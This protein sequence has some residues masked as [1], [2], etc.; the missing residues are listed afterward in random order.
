MV[1]LEDFEAP[2]MP[3]QETLRKKL[4]Q[5]LARFR[6]EKRPAALASAGGLESAPESLVERAAPWP[7]LEPF[8]AAV[9]AAV[10]EWLARPAESAQA[11]VF[12]L[13]PG[14]EFDLMR[15][16][17]EHRAAEAVPPPPSRSIVEGDYSALPRLDGASELVVI[18]R[19]EDWFRRHHAGLA[20]VRELIARLSRAKG[21][22]V[23]GV[24]SWAWR[25]LAPAADTN[26]EMPEP[27]T[28][29]P[30]EAPA[31]CQWLSELAESSRPGAFLFRSDA[32]GEVL[33]DPATSCS[34]DD[35]A[36]THTGNGT[37]F[38]RLAAVSRGNPWLAWHLFRGS[39]RVAAENPDVG[40]TAA[41][42]PGDARETV[43]ID[44]VAEVSLPE[45]PKDV[46]SSALLVFHALLI[47]GDLT[48]GDLRQ[49]LPPIQASQVV[50]RLAAERLLRERHGRWRVA[51]TAYPAVRAALDHAGY[52]IDRL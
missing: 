15:R 31:L 14:E 39:M 21:R 12:V 27:L 19:L 11:L 42:A 34:S 30:F 46:R 23:L 6:R 18:P 28:L 20:L 16:W 13:P 49:V 26:V 32:T 36:D 8:F 40:Q 29:A 4:A 22:C 7:A 50:H 33:V 43:W 5:M 47:H 17:S 38:K 37:F 52:P 35:E 48:L 2:A 9:D 45:L 1:P 25:F 10:D 3:A 24:N 44:P 51:P 41:E